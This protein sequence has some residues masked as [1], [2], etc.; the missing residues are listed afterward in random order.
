MAYIIVT[1]LIT[2]SLLAACQLYYKYKLDQLKAVT[3]LKL[4]IENT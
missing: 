1:F 4:K 3:D 2:S